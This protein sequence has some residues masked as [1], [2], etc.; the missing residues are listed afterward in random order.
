MQY[1][2]LAQRGGQHMWSRLKAV[3][4]VAAFVGAPLTASAQLDSLGLVAQTGSGYGNVNTILTLQSPGSSTTESGCIGPAGVAT[5]M[6]G[7]LVSGTSHSSVYSISQLPG[8][9]GSNLRLFLNFT[10]PGNG[11]NGATLNNA[12]LTL[13]NGTTSIFSSSTGTVNFSNTLTGTGASGFSFGLSP[14]DAALFDSFLANSG[15]ANYTLGLSSS[16]SGVT[17]GPETWYIGTVNGTP[18][19]VP[20]PGS[21]ALLGTGLIGLVPM[22]RRKLRK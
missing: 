2:G 18:S 13:Y 10:E 5:C 11:T 16:L 7:D 1:L 20:E 14:A 6:P 19:T 22:A 4:V 12:T 21:M 15:S 9:S 17:G 8:V 3:A